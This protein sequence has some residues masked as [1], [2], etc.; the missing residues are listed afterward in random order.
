MTLAG[1][2][3]TASTSTDNTVTFD[4]TKPT[5]TINQ[6]AGQTDPT[7][8][9]PIN[10]TVVFSESVTG[11][12]GVDVTLSGTA[13]ATTAAVTG[14][15]TT[16]NVAV[17]GMTSDGTVIATV[18]AGGAQDAAGN[19]NTAS[20]ST[21]NTV[22]YDTTAPTVTNVTSTNANAT[23]TTGDTIHVTVTFSE[24][25]TVTGTPP[26]AARTR[27][28]PT[29]SRPTSAGRVQARSRSTTHVVNGDASGDLDYLSTSALTLNGGTIKDAATNNANLT[30]PSPGAAGS[31]GFNKNIVIDTT[32]NL[33]VTKT[34]GVSSV[35]AGAATVHTYTI[36]VT[37]N[38]PASAANVSLSDTFPV[39]F[40]RGSVAQTQGTCAGSPSFTCA[41]GT[42]ASGAQATVTVD[43]TVPS[44]TTASQTNTATVSSD[45]ADS[46]STNNTANDTDTITASADLSVSKTGPSSVT[47]GDATGFDYTISVHN[48][49]PSDNQ[50]FTVGDTLPAGLTFD[51]VG[52]DA[53]CSAL[54]QAVTCTG[55]SL[56][57]GADVS[58][59]VH[60]KLASTVDSSV[61]LHNSAS[62]TATA[63]TDPNPANDSSNT[64][65]TAVNEDVH[66]SISK[67]FD[68]ATVTAGGAPKTFTISV[69]NSGKSDADNVQVTDTVD[70]AARRRFLRR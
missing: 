40:S 25:V 65:D 16:Y 42:L 52:S 59:V 35:V 45:I 61:T 4:T 51:P 23:Y 30:L 58:F 46:N 47:A 41:L 27:E 66:L 10:F 48:G 62:I 32:A 5:V 44:S 64:V 26:A 70:P 60:V 3:N 38:G 13:G 14:G 37:N 63:T 57:A 54:G 9:S 68:S 20:T 33:S 31:L 55:A 8:S 15:P 22:T 28:R 17:S 2:S 18:P 12:T 21:D 39:G 7:N 43:F 53:N 1:N 6:A 29:S 56:A 34:D 24:P 36:T 69:T 19:T 50:G 67:S 49:G 11:F